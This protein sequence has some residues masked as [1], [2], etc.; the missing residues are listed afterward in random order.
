MVWFGTGAPG[1][2]G[3]RTNNFCCDSAEFCH[4]DPSPGQGYANP[5]SLFRPMVWK[6]LEMD[7]RMVYFS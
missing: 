2:A 5:Q 6:T 4:W 1:A 3:R 7:F